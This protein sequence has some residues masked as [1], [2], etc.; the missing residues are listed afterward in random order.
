MCLVS[1]AGRL[2]LADRAVLWA[3]TLCTR[4]SLTPVPPL[5]RCRH[6]HIG[7]AVCKKADELAAEPLVVSVDG[8]CRS[9]VFGRLQL[10]PD[11]NRLQLY[12]RLG[13]AS[14]RFGVP[15]LPN[16]AHV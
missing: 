13:A 11:W 7:K 9:A 2:Q 16:A 15:C 14:K 8:C 3:R 10:Q 4:C 6:K 12:S 1:R 5:G